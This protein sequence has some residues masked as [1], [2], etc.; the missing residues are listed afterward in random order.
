[1]IQIPLKAGH[2]RPASETPLTCLLGS[3]VIFQGM[4]A[5]IAKKSYIF[6]IFQGGMKADPP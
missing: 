6:V 2:N 1:M 3:F 4:R 5:S